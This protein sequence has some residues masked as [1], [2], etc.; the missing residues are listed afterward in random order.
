MVGI[1]IGQVSPWSIAPRG[2]PNQYLNQPIMKRW[3]KPSLISIDSPTAI[4]LWLCSSLFR[5]PCIPVFY[6]RSI[7]FRCLR[8]I[9]FSSICIHYTPLHPQGPSRNS[10]FDSILSFRLFTK[11]WDVFV[12]DLVKIQVTRWGVKWVGSLLNFRSA[13][14]AG[15]SNFRSMSL[16]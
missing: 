14:T 13:S 12:L 16:F 2:T 10:S 9:S 6:F 8:L 11:P 1:P 15:V 5:T 3:C 4:R 7:N